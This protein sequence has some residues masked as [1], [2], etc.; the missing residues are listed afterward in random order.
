MRYWSYATAG[1][2]VSIA[3]CSASGTEDGADPKPD[4]QPSE[5]GVPLV[6]AGRSD[7]EA[8]DVDLGAERPLLCGDAGFCET[9]LPKSDLGLPLS[10]RRVWVVDSNDVWSVTVEGIVLH[11][12]GVRWT[13]E[14]KANHELY[15]VW[16]SPSSVWVGGEAGLLLHRTAN[17][18]WSHIEAGHVVPIHAVYGNR[19]DDVWFTRE[20]SSVDHFD[21]AGVKNFPIG[22]VSGLTV[23]T[24]FGRPGFGTYAAGHV[25]GVPIVPAPCCRERVP[26][27]PYVF[28]LAPTGISLFS[29]SLAEQRGFVPMAGAVTDSPNAERRV[30]LAGY[31]HDRIPSPGG[32]FSYRQGGYC[33]VG[34]ANPVEIKALSGGAGGIND[35]PAPILAYHGED[36]RLVWGFGAMA[37]WDGTGTIT[38][39]MGYDFSPGE[40]HGAHN[41]ATDSWLVGNGFAL[42]G[43]M[44]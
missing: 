33:F 35:R 29:T 6:D 32:E 31:M 25:P 36:I 30:F 43:V 3:A 14:Y 37:R 11:Y 22:G 19:D 12:D 15:A 41:G 24:V 23:T 18:Q 8:P 9:R 26:D 44:P 16:A 2:L 21:G 13:I 28:E 34:A 42:K 38:L 20:D 39:G 7:S 1:L 27:Q 5:A 10:L 4:E 17:G 40:I